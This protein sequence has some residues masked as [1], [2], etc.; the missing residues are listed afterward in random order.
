MQSYDFLL[1]T[2]ILLDL[3]VV[4]VMIG[5]GVAAGAH[6]AP[7]IRGVAG[8]AV[9]R[10]QVADAPPGKTRLYR[11]AVEFLNRLRLRR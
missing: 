9:T 2:R 5:G 4:A 11:A 3:A 6:A 8:E 10:I 7:G 1:S